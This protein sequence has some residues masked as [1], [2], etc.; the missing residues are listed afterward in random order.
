MKGSISEFELGVLRT[1]MLE[2]AM[3]KARRGELRYTPPVGYLWDR[4]AG[5][6]FD[7]DRFKFLEGR[8]IGGARQ[9]HERIEP[10]LLPDGT[11]YRALE[12]LLVLDGDPLDSST[13]V[14]YVITGGRVWTE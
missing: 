1:R 9:I 12:K 3:A 2:A 4:D 6:L 8:P 7:P 5:V 10:P 14:R 11:I 13:S